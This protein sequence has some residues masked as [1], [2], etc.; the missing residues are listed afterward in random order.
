MTASLQ[1]LQSHMP[2]HHHGPALPG[3]LPASA[4]LSRRPTE[5]DG[6]LAQ[7]LALLRDNRL[8]AVFQP[9]LDYRGHTYIGYEGLIRGPSDSPL[10]MPSALFDVARRHHRIMELER[11]C[12]RAIFEAF[13]ALKLQGTLFVNASPRCLED[14]EFRNGDTLEL[15]R[16]LGLAPSRIVIEL[17]ENQQIHDFDHLHQVLL[18]YRGQGYRFAVDD[19][20]EGFSNL[21]L[22]SELRPEYVKIDRHF[23]QGVAEDALKFQLIRSMHEIAETCGAAIIAEGIEDE[24]DFTTIRDLGIACGQGFFIARPDPKP[25]TQPAGAVIA[26][27]KNRQISVFPGNGAAQ[28]GTTIRALNHYIAPLMPHT[29]NDTVYL[30]FEANP[31]LHVIP[32][33]NNEHQP[34]GLI[35][36]HNLIDRFARPFRRELYGRKP[37]TLFMDPA[38]L[39]VDQH[40][41]VQEVGLMISR[42]AKHYLYDGFIITDGGRYQGVGSGQD[43]MAMITE[44]QISAARYANPLTQLPG[45]VPINEHA[46]RLLASQIPFSA[47]YFDLDNFKPFNDVYGYRKGDDLI[48]RLGHI[49]VE[50]ADPRL[51]FIGHIGGDDFIILFQSPDWEERCT[52]ALGLFDAHV[53]SLVQPEDLLRGG[54]LGE[55]RKGRSVFTPLPSLSIGALRAEPGAFASHHE[56]AAAAAMAKKQA[57]KQAGSSLFIERRRPALATA[58]V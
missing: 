9:I 17:T 42:A 8:V 38:P 48:Q 35:N 50:I 4:A 11:A 40:L 14:P 49:L 53:P 10:H 56:V 58:T 20:G 29:C 25:D 24:A 47:C 55:D 51:D 15:L 12:R 3:Y 13:A 54:F 31:E 22:W 1:S 37:C 46:E 44:M 18:T 6:E 34:I 43:L 57:K 5:E 30:R 28:G 41:S 2:G 52:R 27:I 36:R 33:V 21:R 39:I 16:S 23:V 7:F 19:L 45:N 26:A 32:V